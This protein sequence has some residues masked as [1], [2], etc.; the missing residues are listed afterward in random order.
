MVQSFLQKN[1]PVTY[2]TNG[3]KITS[4]VK[5]GSPYSC[6]PVLFQE[7]ITENN[8]YSGKDGICIL[9]PGGEKYFNECS[10]FETQYSVWIAFMTPSN[11][12][13]LVYVPC[14][15]DGHFDKILKLGS[16]SNSID[17][18]I[19]SIINSDGIVSENDNTTIIDVSKMVA[20]AMV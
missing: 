19:G 13:S 15:F 5:G 14:T 9:T 6:F 10:E 7:Y 18:K 20:S 8:L 12:S 2:E 16:I 17:K 4:L 11:V 3:E 1:Q